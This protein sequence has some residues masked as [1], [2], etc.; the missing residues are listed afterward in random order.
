[1]TNIF[2]LASKTKYHVKGLN[3]E[4]FLF[5]LTSCGISISK[6]K[7]KKQ[8]LKFVAS[9]VNDAAIVQN[10]NK[11]GLS[12]KQ[13]GQTGFI[14]FIKEM[15][16]KI[17]AILGIIYSVFCV[18]HFTGTVAAVEMVVPQNHTCTNHSS[19]IF[20]EENL[21]KLKQYVDQY[22]RVGEKYST[23][24]KALQNQVMANFELVENCSIEKQGYKV[25]IYL[26]EAVGKT[27]GL[28]KQIVA[29]NNCVISSIT[30]YSGKA[31]VKAGDVVKKGQVLVDSVGDV[32]PRADIMA[33][34]WYVGMAVHNTSQTILKETGKLFKSTSIELFGKQ[35]LQ[36]KKCDF[37]YY[38]LKT[39]SSYISNMLLPIK[40]VTNTYAELEVVQQEIPF[41]DVKSKILA[42]SKADALSRTSG[43]PIECTYSIVIQGNL[44]RVDCFLLANEQ[45]GTV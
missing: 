31:L 25:L 37:K 3:L 11:C 24:T 44:V 27:V 41:A 7:R 33:K 45:M 28:A 21:S 29:T 2:Y 20:K 14:K 10:A 22:V 15:P 17:G 36:A 19:C 23:D 8:E 18:M 4:N 9:S 34:V 26:T 5:G 12:I 6:I 40:K 30:T 39:N 16:Y 35:V 38:K 1:M 43:S 13:I 42:Q 32:L